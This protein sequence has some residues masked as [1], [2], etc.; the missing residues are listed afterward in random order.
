MAQMISLSKGK[1][2]LIQ[3]LI[4]QNFD[5][6]FIKFSGSFVY[7][8]IVVF[9][10]Q[11][12]FHNLFFLCFSMKETL[13]H[14]LIRSKRNETGLAKEIMHIERPEVIRHNS[15]CTIPSFVIGAACPKAI[16]MPKGQLVNQ[17]F[18]TYLTFYIP[19]FCYQFLQKL[20]HM[21]PNGYGDPRII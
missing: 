4:S 1:W 8:V 17:V 16:A 20:T 11:L 10:F 3:Y 15:F 14:R 5:L 7:Q 6:D 19:I 13:N 2:Q 21:I 18:F 12:F 9:T